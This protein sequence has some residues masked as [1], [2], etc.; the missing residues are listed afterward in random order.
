MM[1]L[2]LKEVAKHLKMGQVQ[3]LR[4][5]TQQRRHVGAIGTDYADSHNISG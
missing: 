1:W 2:A 4:T 3:I 5:R